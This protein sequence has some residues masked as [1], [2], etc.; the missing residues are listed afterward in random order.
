MTP[1][2]HT[3]DTERLARRLIWFE[4]PA[5]ALADPVRFVAYAL[6]RGTLEDMS[7]LRRYVSDDAIREVLATAPPGIIGERSWAYWH[8]MMDRP[9]PPLPRRRIG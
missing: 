5:E 9:P 7:V 2:P 4:D 6:E 3:A 1:I 8:L